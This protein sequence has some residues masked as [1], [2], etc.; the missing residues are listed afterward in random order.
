ML[1]VLSFLF[2]FAALYVLIYD[3]PSSYI[4]NSDFN[5]TQKGMENDGDSLKT[6][7]LLDFDF[8]TLVTPDELCI[9]TS[10][11]KTE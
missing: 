3:G 4:R 5:D 10:K 9:L 2:V 11:D 6:Q 7:M 8:E 1:F